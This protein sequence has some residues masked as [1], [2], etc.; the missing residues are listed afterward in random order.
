MRKKGSDKIELD[1]NF[2]KKLVEIEFWLIFVLAGLYLISYHVLENLWLC[3]EIALYQ[4]F[5]ILLVT[6]GYIGI[7]SFNDEN[8]N[9]KDLEEINLL[10]I[11]AHNILF[12]FAFYSTILDLIEID[13]TVFYY[14]ILYLLV[15]L[16]SAI[17]VTNYFCDH[18][19]IIN[20]NEYLK[21][22]SGE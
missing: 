12:W 20:F 8:N 6:L 17:L 7:K 10:M 14:G 13:T 16:V 15:S 3:V 4:M 5:M 21:M 11:F 2:W 1:V 22:K 19:K 9:E 18:F